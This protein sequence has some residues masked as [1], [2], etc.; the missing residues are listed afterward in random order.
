MKIFLKR[1][2]LLLVLL[3]SSLDG[4]AISQSIRYKLYKGMILADISLIALAIC[5]LILQ[6]LH[7][8]EES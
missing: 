6:R 1:W 5:I 7:S 3:I 4:Y 2:Q 8:L